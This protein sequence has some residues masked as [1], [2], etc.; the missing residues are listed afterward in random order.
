MRTEGRP[1]KS[2]SHISARVDDINKLALVEELELVEI[3]F[4]MTIITFILP[5]LLQ[6]DGGHKIEQEHL[7]VIISS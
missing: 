6:V 2:N 4:G 1:C 3:T 5:R 7:I